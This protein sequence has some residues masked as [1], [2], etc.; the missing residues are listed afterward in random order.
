MQNNNNQLTKIRELEEQLCNFTI[1]YTIIRLKKLITKASEEERHFDENLIKDLKEITFSYN[2]INEV[3]ELE[4][5]FPL[6]NKKQYL[7][8]FLNKIKYSKNLTQKERYLAQVYDAYSNYCDKCGSRYDYLNHEELRKYLLTKILSFDNIDNS[9]VISN[10]ISSVV[11][12]W[13]STLNKFNPNNKNN[14]SDE[15]Q[16]ELANL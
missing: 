11:N 6:H 9:S 16:K 5:D 15:F 14:L 7:T 13:I 12:V 4:L 1:E 8:E 10:E 2:Y 3:E